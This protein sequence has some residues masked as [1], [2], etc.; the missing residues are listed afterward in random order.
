VVL[1]DYPGA[2]DEGDQSDAGGDALGATVERELSFAVRSLLVE[3]AN[4]LTEAL[5]R[6]RSGRYGTCQ[7]CG[8]GIAAARLRAIPEATRCVRCQEIQ[9]GLR[10]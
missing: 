10:S 8:T 6:V 9:E 5:D 4:R 3:R 1:E 7:I 2:P